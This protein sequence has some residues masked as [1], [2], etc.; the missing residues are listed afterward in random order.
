[1][2]VLSLCCL[3]WETLL[4]YIK[5]ICK[6]GYKNRDLDQV[7]NKTKQTTIS[8]LAVIDFTN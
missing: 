4:T 8:S 7:L 2:S 6:S 3:T 1:M 5:V